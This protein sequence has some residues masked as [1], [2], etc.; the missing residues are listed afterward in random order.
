MKKRIISMLLLVVMLLG[1]L[2]TAAFAADSVEEAL[3]EIDIYNGGVRMSYLSINGI[4]REL[5]YTY[6]NYIDRN[7]QTREIPAYCVNPNIK[8]VPQTVSEGESI[9]YLAEE[10]GSDPKVV[11]IVANGY[12]TRSLSELGVENKYHAYYA[13]KAAL[14]CYLLPN[15]DINNLKVNPSLTGVELQRAQQILAAAKDIYRRGTSWT[16]VLTPGMRVWERYFDRLAKGQFYPNP[17][18]NLDGTQA[19]Y[20]DEIKAAL[21]DDSDDIPKTVL[22]QAAKTLENILEDGYVDAR[23]ISAFPGRFARGIMLN[24]LRFS[25][26][27]P[28]IQTMLNERYYDHSIIMNLLIQ[29]V[30]SGEVNNLSEYTGELLDK[31]LEFIPTVDECIRDEDARSRCTAVTSIL[32][33]IWPILQRCFDPLRKMKQDVENQ[34]KANTSNNQSPAGGQQSQSNAGNPQGD[35]EDG[36]SPANGAGPTAGAAENAEGQATPEE[37]GM[38]AVI[39]ALAG[40]VAKLAEMPSGSNT[41]I[42]F[43]GVVAMDEEEKQQLMEAVSRVLSEETARIASRVTQGFEQ[44]E[45]GTVTYNTGYAGSGYGDAASDTQRMLEEMAEAQVYEAMEEELSEELQREADS[46]SYGN[47]H[48]GI[49]VTVNRMVHIDQEMIDSYNAIAPELLQLSKRLQRSIRSVLTDKRQGGNR[50]VCSPASASTSTRCTAMTEGYS[51]TAD[52]LR[53]PSTWRLHCWSMN[54]AV[55]VEVIGSPGHVQRPSLSMTS[56]RSLGSL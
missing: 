45:G 52:C 26:T 21:L 55:C 40:Q 2:P 5:I 51:V 34:Q 37:A 22:F 17:P 3:G 29:Y 53:S 11:G 12:P 56:A 54:R 28:E 10:R 35:D 39:S 30:R 33:G 23:M 16:K 49:D 25:E 38:E 48:R 20:A 41:P 47:A 31:L 15:W 24:N 4:N 32:I 14:W 46:I 8:G 6:Y 1:M 43:N 18:H 19:L 7:G 42:P 44:G 13:T 50:L 36:A 27:V 9:K